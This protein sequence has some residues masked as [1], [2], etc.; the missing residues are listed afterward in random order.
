MFSFH[1]ERVD[2]QEEKIL[3]CCL[4]DFQ[5]KFEHFSKYSANY[6]IRVLHFLFNSNKVIYNTMMKTLQFSSDKVV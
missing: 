3:I 5:K 6:M 2:L 1:V 4:I